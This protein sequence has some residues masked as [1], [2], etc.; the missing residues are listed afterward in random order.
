MAKNTPLSTTQKAAAV[1]YTEGQIYKY[2]FPCPWPGREAATTPSVSL[3]RG[4]RN[5]SP[6]AH[7]RKWVSLSS[8]PFDSP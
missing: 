3:A 4:K 5:V 2:F 1:C 8:R 7:K 6:A